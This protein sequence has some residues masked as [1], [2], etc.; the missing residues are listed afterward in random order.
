[1]TQL[2]LVTVPEP[3]QPSGIQLRCCSVE[4]LLE[5]MPGK[6]SLIVADPPWG[7]NQAPG[8][9]SPELQYETVSDD[10]IAEWIASAYEV[11]DDARL[12]LWCTWPKL[13]EWWAAADAVG[14]GWQ[15]KT[16]GSWHKLGPPGV[17]HHWRGHSEPVLIYTKGSPGVATSML[18][19]AHSSHRGRHSE[20]PSPWVEGWLE[21]WTE[22]G[23]LV[24]DLFA[25]SSG[26]VAR[27]CARM[28]RR[29]VGAELDPE[30]YRQAVDRLALDR[31][32][33]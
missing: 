33:Q 3:A 24:C 13:G 1:M 23:D 6:P 20:K 32:S 26:C 12:A 8:V 29:Y 16:G 17:G 7:Y 11:C 30:R 2:S 18:R 4:D 27:A 10:L 31:G 14:I 28:G 9:S 15:Y 22:A 21:R 5:D 19:N 25:G